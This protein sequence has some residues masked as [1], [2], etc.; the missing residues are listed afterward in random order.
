MV[1]GLAEDHGVTLGPDCHSNA[2]LLPRVPPH[3][4]R[5]VLAGRPHPPVPGDVPQD[6][7]LR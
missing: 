2:A 7:P 5:I 4:L 1:D 6:H 3:G